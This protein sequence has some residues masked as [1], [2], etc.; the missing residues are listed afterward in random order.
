MASRSLRTDAIVLR[1]IRYGE[2]DRILHLYTPGARPPRRDRE[3]R[4]Q[5]AQPLRRAAGAVLPPDASTSTSA[6]ATSTPSRPPT[7]S[8]R[9]ARCASERPRS[10]P[11]RAPATRSRACSRP[12]TRAPPSSTCWR[13]TSRCSTAT[14]A[15]PRPRRSSPSGSSCS[16]PAASRRSSPPAP[17]AGRATTSAASRARPA[18]SSAW[19][20]RRRPSRSRRRRTASS[21]PRWED[22]LAEAPEASERALRQ[23]ERAIAE[24][25]EH[26][27]HVHAASRWRAA[28]ERAV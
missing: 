26:H 15:P 16:S 18:A 11:P 24:T 17:R 8:T 7:R 14:R 21:S 5:N 12:T 1:S 3:G 23:A 9:T 22:L 13:T 19:P 28:A 6:A 4:A 2:A 10:T 27:A 25:A 20:A